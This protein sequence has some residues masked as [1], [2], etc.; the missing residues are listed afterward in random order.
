MVRIC[1]NALSAKV[2]DGSK[3]LAQ[4]L[5][6]QSLFT[7]T[8]YKKAQKAG[9]SVGG[10][11]SSGNSGSTKP[12]E[13]ETP[14]GWTTVVTNEAPDF[15]A[16]NVFVLTGEAKDKETLELNLSLDGA[17]ELCGFDFRLKYDV[18]R[19]ELVSVN[20]E[21]DLSLVFDMESVDG[22]IAFNCAMVN[23]IKKPKRILS[24][25]FHV[26]G[27]GGK[28]KIELVPVEVTR[29]AENNDVVVAPYTL[30]SVTVEVK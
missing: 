10:A 11:S 3:T 5:M 29:I 9:T 30:T 16:Q 18:N 25:V 24:A 21:Y 27:K 6:D 13:T 26:L 4:L 15:T 20:T 28:D 23:N 19:Y 12:R 22:E 1:K 17:V 7:E 14:R 2:K 8:E